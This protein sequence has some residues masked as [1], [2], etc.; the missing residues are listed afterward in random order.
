MSNLQLLLSKPTVANGNPEREWAIGEQA[1]IRKGF[2]NLLVTIIDMYSDGT[3]E[4]EVW[5]SGT[6]VTVKSAH[7]RPNDYEEKRLSK[8][9]RLRNQK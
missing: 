2:I 9:K 7:L 8:T 1:I 3:Y 4:A 5:L 6:T